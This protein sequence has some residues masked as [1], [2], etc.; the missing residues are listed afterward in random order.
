MPAYVVE[1][2]VRA[3]NDERK[4]VRGSKLLI[5]G[6]AYKPDVDDARESPSFEL[7]EQ[8]KALGANIDYHD[9]HIP[10][11]PKTRTHGLDLV[12]SSIELTEH[13]LRNYDAVVIATHHS[14]Y[15]WA[16]LGDH[17]RLIV[18]TRGVMKGLARSRARVVS[19]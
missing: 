15:D 17:A 9:P 3:L 7:I 5:L 14:S 1:Q 18:D 12:G 16:W 13:S 19:A 10:I 4:A 11:A 2:V 6:L 8:L